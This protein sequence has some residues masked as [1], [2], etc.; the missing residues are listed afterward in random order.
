MGRYAFF[1]TGFEYKFRFGVQPS[2]DIRTFGG[3]ASYDQSEKGYFT[4]HWEESDEKAILHDLEPLAEAL[5]LP[6]PKFEMYE[7][8]LQ[9]SY[10]FHQELYDLYK[11]DLNEQAVARFSLGCMI[12]HQLQYEKQ[13]SVDYES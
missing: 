6:L 5:G 4:H 13:L 2:E 3:Y 9:G 10:K 1:K 11:Q 8:N 7:K 12:Y